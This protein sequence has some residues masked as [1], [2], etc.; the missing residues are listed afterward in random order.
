MKSFRLPRPDLWVGV[1]MIVILMGTALVSPLYPLYQSAWALPA[2]RV[3]LLYVIYM[4]GA[5]M[6]LL[7]FGRLADQLGYGRV[8]GAAIAL[9]FTGCCLSIVAPGFYLFSFARFLVGIA[10][11]LITTSGTVAVM[12]LAPEKSRQAVPVLTSLFISAGF[13]AGPVV[14]GIAGQW[15]PEPL[16]SAHVPSVIL[17]MICIAAF[18]FVPGHPGRGGL[19]ARS[20][21][22]R[23]SWTAPE[24]S[25]KFALA[26]AIAFLCFGTF[27]LYASLAP[28]LIRTLTGLSGPIV[29]GLYIGIFLTAATTF[30]ILAGRALP[31]R[32]ASIGLV[33]MAVG[34]TI[35]WANLDASSL[36]L[37]ATGIFI[38]AAAH[39]LC[40]QAS[41]AVLYQSAG[42][43]NRGGL[44]ATYWAVGYS[45]S[46]FPLLVLGWGSDQWG[47]KPAVT[48]FCM[49]GVALPL[50]LA[51]LIAR[52]RPAR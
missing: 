16:I 38:A 12:A 3:T 35:L 21:L 20:L 48:G 18:V 32:T 4:F 28:I 23:L 29:I 51:L 30:Q 34:Y 42:P 19:T 46:I 37:F 36:W 7:V 14:G 17:L 49:A 45:G 27:G 44:T 22:P 9:A 26:C 6:S 39:G 8:M 1:I 47:V 10:A 52:R 43:D 11:S 41:T 40:V 24:H 15:A 5:L 50:I 25:V 31:K 13:T 33:L 2:S